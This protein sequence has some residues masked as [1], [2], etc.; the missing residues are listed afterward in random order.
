MAKRKLES[1]EE[2]DEEDVA[3]KPKVR[4]TELRWKSGL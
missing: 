4:P 1:E 2:G 3:K